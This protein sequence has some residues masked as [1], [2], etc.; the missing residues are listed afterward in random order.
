M[1]ITIPA[2]LLTV[3]AVWLSVW[4]V[5]HTLSD[6]IDIKHKVKE[7]RRLRRQS[8]RSAGE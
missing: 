5:S 8:K 3:A 6:L 4:L 2:W 1:T 7:L